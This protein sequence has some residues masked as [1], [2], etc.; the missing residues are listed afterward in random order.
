MNRSKL[1]RRARQQVLVSTLSAALLATPLAQA[2]NDYRVTEPGYGSMVVDGLIV[3]PL[4]L[5][6]T[7]VGA[8]AWVVTLPFS[9]LGGNVG[10][11]AEDLV[12]DP[13][14]F[15]FTRPLGDL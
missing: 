4:G 1:I 6:A 9:A 5:A 13:A 15:T 8:A 7:I 3:R 11:A 10:E 2:A 14:R 12:V